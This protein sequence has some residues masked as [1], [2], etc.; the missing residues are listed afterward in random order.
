MP[1][2]CPICFNAL[3]GDVC[4]LVADNSLG[5]PSGHCVCIECLTKLVEPCDEEPTGFCYRCPLCRVDA[6]LS[7]LHVMVL[8]YGSWERAQRKFRCE[9]DVRR[10]I[11]SKIG[12]EV[13]CVSRA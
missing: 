7:R 8:I 1:A 4:G 3:Q 6:G 9:Q 11:G 2:E 12:A 10:W 13:A 5:C